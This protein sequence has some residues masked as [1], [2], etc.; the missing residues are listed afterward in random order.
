[1]KRWRIE[2][3]ALEHIAP[4]AENMR[5]VDKR[6]VWA[7]DRQTPLEALILSFQHAELAWTCFVDGSPA[8]MWGVSV[9]GGMMSFTG[10]PWLLGTEALRSVSVEFLKQS[11]PYVELM[12][13][14]FPRLEN[15]VHTGNRLSIRW[16]RWCGFVLADERTEINGEA[17]FKFWRERPCAR[18]PL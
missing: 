7:S 17:F 4:I 18:C 14:R 13:E 16:L 15:Y 2:T 8:F 3:A 1:M 12:Q 10:I 11:V 9:P 6:E 5:E